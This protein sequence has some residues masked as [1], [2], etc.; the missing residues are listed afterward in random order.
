MANFAR[1]FNAKVDF[2]HVDDTPW[3]EDTDTDRLLDELFA[4]TDPD[5]AFEIHNIKRDNVVSG[6][7][8]YADK[9]KIDLIAFVSKHRN[10]WQNLIHSSVSQNVAISTHKPMLIMHFDD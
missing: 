5:F 8:N 7:K 10:F 4:E 1:I 9:H 6:L 3:D 2:V